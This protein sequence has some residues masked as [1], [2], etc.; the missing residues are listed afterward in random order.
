[1]KKIIKHYPMTDRLIV[2]R[3]YVMNIYANNLNTLF[4]SSY[5]EYLNNILNLNTTFIF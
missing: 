1:M 2:R 4:Y 5:H 3:G